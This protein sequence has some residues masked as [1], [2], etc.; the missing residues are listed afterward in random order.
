MY[1][2]SV[3]W[4]MPYETDM[5]KLLKLNHKPVETVLTELGSGVMLIAMSSR[6]GV[7]WTADR[8]WSNTDDH[9]ISSQPTNC[10][11]LCNLYWITPCTRYIVKANARLTLTWT[12]W[13]TR[14]RQSGPC[15]RRSHPVTVWLAVLAESVGR[16][17]GRT[18]ANFSLGVTG[19]CMAHFA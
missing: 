12:I 10:H 11:G 16:G 9:S 4:Q 14:S 1:Y 3:C 7:G 6:H 15:S 2:H 17:P 19:D 13:L 5:L 18:V 8:V